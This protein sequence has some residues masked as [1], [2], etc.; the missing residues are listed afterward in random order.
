[1]SRYSNLDIVGILEEHEAI[2]NGHFQLPSGFHSQSYVQTSL[3]MQ[4]PHIAQQVAKAMA[5]RFPQDIDVVLAPSAATSV[6]GQEVARAKKARAIYAERQNGVMMLKR[7][8]AVKEGE[9]I[10]IV[11]DVITSGNQANEAAVLLTRLGARVI[12][13]TAI[14]DRSTGPLPLTVPARSLVTYPLQ[15]FTPDKCP[16]CA[17][18]VPL[19]IPGSPL[20]PHLGDK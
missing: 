14:V 2:L 1:M 19:T 15:C 20:K 6:I 13:V 8:F 18:G 7:G 11:D 3:V 5:A 16:L 17:Q 12:G 4:Y 9:R 10:L